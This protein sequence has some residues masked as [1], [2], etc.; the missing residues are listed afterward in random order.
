MSASSPS[1]ASAASASPD[2]PLSE[3][4]YQ[5]L[6]GKILRCEFEP[7]VKLKMDALQRELGYSSSP[8]REALNRL[9]TEGLVRADDRRGFWAASVSVA[10]LRDVTR[11]RLMLDIEALEESMQVGDHEWEARIVSSLHWLVKIEEKA[12]TAAQAEATVHGG[13]PLTLNADWSLRHKEFHMALLSAC[14]SPKLLTMVSGLF[15][16]AERYRRLS[17]RYR[18]EPRHKAAEHRRIMEAVI[19]RKSAEAVALL[20]EHTSRTAENV[21]AAMSKV[22]SLAEYKKATGRTPD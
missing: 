20:R 1:V 3:L 19:G 13:G 2:L 5:T 16:Q 9:V 18:K 12:Q 8:L 6:R 21:E 11:L 17:M 7:G 10:D 15:D 14:S 22:Q 4:A